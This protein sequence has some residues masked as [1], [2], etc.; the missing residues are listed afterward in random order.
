MIEQQFPPPSDEDLSQLFRIISDFMMNGLESLPEHTLEM[1]GEVRAQGGHLVATVCPNPPSIAAAI[2][3]EETET[4]TLL[5][6]LVLE[7]SPRAGLH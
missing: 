4:S 5:F 7:E 6:S 2:V 3:H 1:I